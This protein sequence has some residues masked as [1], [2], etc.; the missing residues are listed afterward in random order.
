MKQQAIKH[1]YAKISK[2]NGNSKVERFFKSLKYEFLNLFFIFS[3]SKVDRLLKEYFIYYNEYRPHEALD[4]QT[5]DEIYQGK[6][7]DKPSKDAKVI[8]GPIEKITLGEGLLNAYQ[9]K[10]VA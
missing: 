4:G 2:A 5:P 3:K 8:K 1:R 10:K 9:L 7:S 6:S